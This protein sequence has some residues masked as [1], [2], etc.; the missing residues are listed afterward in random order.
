MLILWG[1]CLTR[2]HAQF[3]MPHIG[4]VFSGTLFILVL[5]G[6][7]LPTILVPVFT[8]ALVV[9]SGTLLVYEEKTR[10][11]LIIPFLLPKA[12]QEMH[13]KQVQSYNLKH[14]I[15]SQCCLLL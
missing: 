12:P 14:W 6:L 4:M 5:I 8:T 11:A 2:M 13:F 7:A 3:S 15:L 9:V 1:E 10:N